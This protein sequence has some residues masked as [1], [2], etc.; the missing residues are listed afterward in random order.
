ME[1]TSYFSLT[2]LFFLKVSALDFL[3][4]WSNN[5]K[6]YDV[7]TWKQ[8]TAMRMILSISGSKDQRTMKFGQLIEYNTRN[9]YFEKPYTKCSRETIC[10]LFSK[11][12]K[13]RA[14]V[15]QE[16]NVWY[17]LLY[18]KLR[19]IKLI[20]NKLQIICFYLI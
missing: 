9:I 6:I 4:M 7:T 19:A 13:L 8:K 20:E 3:I 16:S 5:F 15:N 14:S 17:I 12:S 2:A 18:V 11:T 1:N 10:R